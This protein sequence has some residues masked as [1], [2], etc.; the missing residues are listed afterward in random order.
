MPD[1]K[2]GIYTVSSWEIFFKLFDSKNGLLMNYSKKHNGTFAGCKI[3]IKHLIDGTYATLKLQDLAK[4][5][6]KSLD[7]SEKYQNEVKMAIK[8][9]RLYEVT[10]V[11][12]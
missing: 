1:D 9:H 3:S 10:P 2:V 6:G 11:G 12:D 4:I 5:L 7:E 8:E